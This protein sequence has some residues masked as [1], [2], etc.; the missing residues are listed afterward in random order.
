MPDKIRQDILDLLPHSKSNNP[1]LH[2]TQIESLESTAE[3]PTSTVGEPKVSFLTKTI[4]MATLALI[5]TAI[6][7]IGQVSIGIPDEVVLNFLMV[8]L[9]NWFVKNGYKVPDFF[10]K[11]K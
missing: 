4:S 9:Y 10:H 8:L 6:W 2:Q 7:G 3:T 11:Q 1:E 5:L